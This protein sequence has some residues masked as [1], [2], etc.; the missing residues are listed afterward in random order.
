[1][2]FGCEETFVDCH[3]SR[4]HSLLH[5]AQLLRDAISFS[6]SDLIVI[7]GLTNRHLPSGDQRRRLPLGSTRRET[8]P[9][10][11]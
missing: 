11:T 1:M 7:R 10:K 2:S 3:K 6:R 5:V 9:K 8:C 4:Y